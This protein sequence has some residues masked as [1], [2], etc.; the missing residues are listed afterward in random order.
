[1]S[2]RFSAPVEIGAIAYANIVLSNYITPGDYMS[3]VELYAHFMANVNLDPTLMTTS[4]HLAL[5]KMREMFSQK[6]PPYKEKVGI[7]ITDGK[8][9]S[10]IDTTAVRIFST[11]YNSMNDR[12]K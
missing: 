12:L 10:A 2:S 5:E 8:S 1:M 4:T 6:N 9:S 11:L 7:V 3:F